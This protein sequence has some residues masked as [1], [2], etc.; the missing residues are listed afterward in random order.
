MP[1]T[2]SIFNALKKPL[3]SPSLVYRPCV[4]FRRCLVPALKDCFWEF[5]RSFFKMAGSVLYY[6]FPE[7]HSPFGSFFASIRNGP[8]VGLFS[9]YQ[10]LRCGCP[11]LE[12]RIVLE[13]QGRPVVREGSPLA[14]GSTEQHTDQPW[15]VLWSRHPGAHLASSSLALVTPKKELCLESVYGYRF[16]QGDPACRYFRLPEPISL[17]GNW[18]SIVSRWVP[19]SSDSIPN[20]SHWLLDALPRLA[21]LN[22]FPLDT[23]IIVPG[24]LAAYQ[25]ESLAML[26]LSRDRLRPSP[27]NHLQVENYY[28]SS[29][30]SMVACYNPYAMRFLRTAFLEKRDRSYSGPKRFFIRRNKQRDIGNSDEVERFFE[31]LGWAIID[32]SQLTFAQEIQLFYE[33]EAVC[34]MGGSALNNT[35]FSRPECAVVM[36]GHDYWVD[37]VLDWIIQ[38]AEIKKYN[39]HIYPSND[40]RQFEVDLGILEQQ[41]KSF[42]L[43]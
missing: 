40:C 25:W 32:P 20:H 19:N 13:D 39:W 38:A 16:Y 37:G 28:F 4:L 12:G 29:P 18:T 30:T 7:R 11:R 17:E 1:F 9:A 3:R 14:A 34:G 23:R 31:R 35:I 41:L 21:L 15:P 10:T 8:P 22:E 43:L 2:P 24:K 5:Y 26:G 33:A 27:E 36:M 42:G 6:V